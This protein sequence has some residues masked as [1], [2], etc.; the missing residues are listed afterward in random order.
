M[1]VTAFEIL[2]GAVGLALVALGVYGILR[3]KF[4]TP[5]S[6]GAL[7]GT[8]SLPLSGLLVILGLISLGFAVYLPASEGVKSQTAA[9]IDTPGIVVSSP[10]PSISATPGPSG[11]TSVT[12]TAPPTGR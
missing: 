6:G 1:P 2:L 9:P 7:G 3:D 4:G 10:A 8:I 12:G 5:T 11:K